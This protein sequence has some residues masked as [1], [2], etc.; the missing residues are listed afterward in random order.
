MDSSIDKT[1]HFRLE[2]CKEKLDQSELMLDKGFYNDALLYSFLS[3]FYAIRLMLIDHDVDSDD[4][5]KIL[6]IAE[7]YYE[8]AGW[9]LIDVVAVL[10]ESKKFK[11]RIEKTPGI[12]VS[13]EEAERF[14]KNAQQVYTEVSKKI[15]THAH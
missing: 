10:R 15:A 12:T 6:E 2:K 7:H 11:D 13:R 8:P 3:I 1:I 14:F 4:E 5:E 9:D